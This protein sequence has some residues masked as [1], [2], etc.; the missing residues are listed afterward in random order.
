MLEK[1]RN[2]VHNNVHATYTVFEERGEKY[3]QID[4]YGREERKM[5]GKTSQT[6]QINREAAEYLVDLLKREFNL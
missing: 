4:T 2:Q 3:F 6:I 1:E 5:P